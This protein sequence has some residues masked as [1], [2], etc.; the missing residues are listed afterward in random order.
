M[1]YFKNPKLVLIGVALIV[2]SLG[3][4]ITACLLHSPVKEISRDELDRLLGTRSI[5]DGRVIP[6]PYAGIYRVEG[7]RK[8]G[9]KTQ[10][11]SV[12]THLDEAQVKTLFA[13]NGMKV[14]MPGQ[15]IRGQWVNIV[16]TL[17]IGG[18][19]VGV[20]FYQTNIGK[21]KNSQV[22]QRPTVA[23]RDVAGVEEAKG[24]VQEIVDFVR[25]PKKYQRRVGI[26]PRGV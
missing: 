8:A 24:E 11:F 16:C 25:D 2:L 21:G 20:V 18:L 9:G 1:K 7:T 14:Q 13:Q 15:G 23:F 17:L 4:I 6:T 5:A 19:V 3:T 22:R 10:K 12:M 26:V